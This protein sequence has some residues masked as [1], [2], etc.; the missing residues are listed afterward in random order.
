MNRQAIHD[1]E[2]G[3][4]EGWYDKDSAEK[5]ASMTHGAGYYTYHTLYKSSGG[6]LIV[7]VSDNCGSTDLHRQPE[8]EKEIAEILTEGYYDGDNQEMIDCLK[9]WEK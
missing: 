5:I 1:G 8:G 9:N 6:R 3:E 2:T 7:K 4:Y